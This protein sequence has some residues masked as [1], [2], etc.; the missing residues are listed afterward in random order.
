MAKWT[1]DR[2]LYL[3]EDGRVVDEAEPGRKTLLAPQGASL[4]EE[5]CR[6]YGL[7]P[8]A[9]VNERPHPNPLPEGEGDEGAAAKVEATVP[10]S[11]DGPDVKSETEE[12]G[13]NTHRHYYRVDGTCRCG[14]S[15]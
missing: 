2:R 13:T 12:A 5:F 4:T 6:R 11:G 3:S 1:T 9:P 10:T 8:Y 14:A 15:R 7:G